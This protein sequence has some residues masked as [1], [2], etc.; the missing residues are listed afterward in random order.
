MNSRN[1]AGEIKFLSTP[2]E[3]TLAFPAFESL[4]PKMTLETFL[5]NRQNC[6]DG[7]YQL[8]GL[9]VDAKVVCVAGITVRPHVEHKKQIEIE[10]FSTHPAHKR[11]GYGKQ[12]IEWII[13]FARESNCFRIK[14]GS[15]ASREDAHLFYKSVG[16]SQNGFKFEMRF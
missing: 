15:G 16:F 9:I 14:L 1:P 3:W 13:S 5:A 12:V 8:L 6:L 4:R 2:E 10:D 7:G 11:K